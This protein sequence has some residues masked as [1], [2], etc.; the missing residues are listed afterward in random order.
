M[1]P[2]STQSGNGEKDL[3]RSKKKKKKQQQLKK[4]RKEGSDGNKEP[5]KK[6][7]TTKIKVLFIVLQV[8]SQ[9]RAGIHLPIP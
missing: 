8:R 6:K 2:D 5:T 1:V 4:K 3:Q 9:G 7:K